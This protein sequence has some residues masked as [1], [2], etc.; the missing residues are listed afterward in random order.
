MFLSLGVATPKPLRN[1]VNQQVRRH[2]MRKARNCAPTFE[3]QEIETGSLA[4]PFFWL[5]GAMRTQFLTGSSAQ[6]MTQNQKG[7]SNSKTKAP[8]SSD[9]VCTILKTEK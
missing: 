7:K 6:L 9:R 1:N 2:L 5:Q 8:T 4:H 3:P